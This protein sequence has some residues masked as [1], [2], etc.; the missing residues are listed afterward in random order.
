MNFFTQKNRATL[1]SLRILDFVFCLFSPIFAGKRFSQSKEK[2]KKSPR[3]WI[4]LKGETVSKWKYPCE[5]WDFSPIIFRSGSVNNEWKLPTRVE[6]L[7]RKSSL[8][9][10]ESRLQVAAGSSS[11]LVLPHFQLENKTMMTVIE[12]NWIT[13]RR[14]SNFQMLKNDLKM[15]WKLRYRTLAVKR[16]NFVHSS[17]VDVKRLT[18]QLLLESYRHVLFNH[19]SNSHHDI[20]HD[21][22]QK[23]DC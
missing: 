20:M 14:Y 18:S 4:E 2:A 19:P 8:I 13:S 15:M 7:H 21:E 11:L 16:A 9:V 12:V 6:V 3:T 23:D 5:R 22:A 17:V 1:A 10:V